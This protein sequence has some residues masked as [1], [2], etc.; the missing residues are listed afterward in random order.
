[1]K[2]LANFK[3]LKFNLTNKMSNTLIEILIIEQMIEEKQY[4]NDFELKLLIKYKNHL[5]KQYL[6][7]FKSKNKEQIKKYNELM[8]K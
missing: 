7:N 3:E 2:Q 4:K 1:M 5:T 8:N 6:N